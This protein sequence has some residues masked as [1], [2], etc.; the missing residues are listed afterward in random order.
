MLH[1]LLVESVVTVESVD[2]ID[3][4]KSLASIVSVCFSFSLFQ[5]LFL[6]HMSF[7]FST[8]SPSQLFH[9][10]FLSCF[11][12]TSEMPTRSLPSTMRT[13]LAVVPLK[14]NGSSL[15]YSLMVPE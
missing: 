10:Y 9:F 3:P 6:K 12:F 1:Y 4:M 5:F 11:T 15:P 7:C 8:F 14:V 13:S 2:L